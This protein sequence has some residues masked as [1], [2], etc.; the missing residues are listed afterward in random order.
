MAFR[1]AVAFVSHKKSLHIWGEFA[2]KSRFARCFIVV[3]HSV[4]ISDR[5][6]HFE[7]I[8]AGCWKESRKKLNLTYERKSFDLL[9]LIQIGF[10]TF[11]V[12]FLS[13]KSSGVC[14]SVR[15]LRPAPK[16]WLSY[17]H[18]SKSVLA[19]KACSIAR[20]KR[21]DNK[22]LMPAHKSSCQ[23]PLVLILMQTFLQ[24]SSD[25]S[26]SIRWYIG[27][28]AALSAL[29]SQSCSNQRTS[30]QACYHPKRALDH[31]LQERCVIK[32]SAWF[33]HWLSDMSGGLALQIR[34]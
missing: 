10:S 19:A 14:G 33:F 18:H 20:L 2:S 21:R 23:M 9:C 31:H 5:F 8:A 1:Y 15:A 27:E 6:S 12:P 22:N 17:L 16:A 28:H 13:R 30:S 3:W 24:E 11:C 25:S 4:I 26:S 34:C 7:F 32:S 29:S